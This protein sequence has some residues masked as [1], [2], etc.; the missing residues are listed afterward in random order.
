MAT[1][2]KSSGRQYPLVASL[3]LNIGTDGAINSAGA[4][5][6]FN[7]AG[8]GIFDLVPLPPGAKLIGGSVVVE[9]ASNDA[10]TATISVG[11]SVSATRYLAATTIKTAAI[12]PLVLTGYRGN[13][14]DLRFTLANGTGGATAGV[15]TAHVTYVIENRAQEVQVS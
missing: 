1:I 3:V 13:G 7:A 4:L 15:V 6:A 10:G 2:Q 8:S 14:E 9:T 11:D 12:T 5:A